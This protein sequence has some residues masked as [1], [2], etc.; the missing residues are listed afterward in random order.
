MIAMNGF[1]TSADNDV[2]ST[3]P[4]KAPTKPGIAIVRTTRQSTLS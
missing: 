3:A 4:A 2:S 1:A